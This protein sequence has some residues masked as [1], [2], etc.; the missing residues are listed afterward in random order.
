M[1]LLSLKGMLFFLGMYRKCGFIMKICNNYVGVTCVDG[2]CPKA[3]WEEY[4]ERGI[5][6]TWKCED[7]SYRKG[8]EDCALCD[9]EYCHLQSEI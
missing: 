1:N 9:S 6:V 5:P 7:C 3:N 8:C 2:S 4:V